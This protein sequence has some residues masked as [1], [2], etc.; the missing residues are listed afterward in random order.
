MNSSGRM[1]NRNDN[2][3]LKSPLCDY[4]SFKTPLESSSGIDLNP[5]E[6]S[7]HFGNVMSYEDENTSYYHGINKCASTNIITKTDNIAT[8]NTDY[9]LVNPSNNRFYYGMN[10]CVSDD[11]KNDVIKIQPITDITSP[12]LA[13]T[14]SITTN[15]SVDNS[16]NNTNNKKCKSATSIILFT[17]AIIIIAAYFP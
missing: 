11:I 6:K 16:V 12:V 17:V 9:N 10:H 5:F 15:N 8:K 1:C 13:P 14:I 4:N 7:E 3:G 2:F